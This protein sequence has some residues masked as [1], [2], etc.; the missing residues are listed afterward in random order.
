MRYLPSAFGNVLGGSLSHSQRA[1]RPDDREG[2][3][4]KDGLRSGWGRAVG[5]IE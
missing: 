4:G 2:S 1:H 5:A 3:L